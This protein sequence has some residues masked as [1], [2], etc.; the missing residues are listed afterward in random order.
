MDCSLHERKETKPNEI[1]KG[2]GKR[3]RRRNT[4]RDEKAQE[5]GR[6]MEREE[7]DTEKKKQTHGR[8]SMRRGR[9]KKLIQQYGLQQSPGN[10]Y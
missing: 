10:K 7:K 4:A 5:G 8:G 9:W 3:R 1:R 2:G 6:N